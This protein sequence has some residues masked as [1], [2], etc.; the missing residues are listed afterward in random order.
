MRKCRSISVL[1][2]LLLTTGFVVITSKLA[3]VEDPDDGYTDFSGDASYQSE[4][5]YEAETGTASTST[6]TLR[7]G[8]LKNNFYGYEFFFFLIPLLRDRKKDARIKRE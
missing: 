2:C 3:L 5:F 1:V 8:Q 6:E 7:V 4:D